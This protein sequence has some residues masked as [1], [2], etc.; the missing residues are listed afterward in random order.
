MK[1]PLDM[2]AAI[3]SYWGMYAVQ[4]VI[5]SVIASVLAECAL[6]CWNIRAPNVKQWFRFMVVLLPIV[7]FPVYQDIAP[8][9]GD[10]YF[11]LESLLDSNRLFF[12]GQWGGI[13]LLTL[14]AVILA[15]TSAIFIFQ[16][17]VPIVSHMFE[18]AHAPDGTPPR[19]AETELV[20][21]ISKALKG[22]PIDESI[23]RIVD[24]DDLSLSSSTGL[25]PMIY[26]S[27]GLIES[28]SPDHLQVALA[29]E[30]AH[31][32]RSKKPVLVLAYIL[33]VIVFFN[34]VAMIEFR[35]LAH[36]EEKV[37]D[38]IAVQLTGKPETLTEAI[39]MLRPTED[40]YDI[41]TSRGA[42]RL[43]LSIEYYSHDLQLKSRALRIGQARQDTPLWGIPLIVTVILI[44]YINYFVV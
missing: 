30:I 44:E 43:A 29:H 22:L 10:L 14:F 2:T 33:R 11:R 28:F 25:S 39:E 32:R 27:R 31:I 20:Q 40:D 35:R 15:A 23:V 7:S 4:I 18:Q 19:E 12:V 5:H 42:E 24:H 26:V 17:L 6:L 38:D 8:D 3:S 16:E 37:C 9:R 36:E 21:K 34:P 13:S 1:I 41:G